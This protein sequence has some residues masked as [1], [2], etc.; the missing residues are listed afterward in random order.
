MNKQRLLNTIIG[1]AIGA[2]L[3]SIANYVFDLGF[4]AIYIG[5]M[6]ATVLIL[7]LL[8]LPWLNKKEKNSKPQPASNLIV[9]MVIF[10]VA[11]AVI[12]GIIIF[13]GESLN[14]GP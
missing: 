10:I 13:I 14:L 9:R 4:N 8:P 6:A 3:I 7:G 2:L 1:V 5:A 11:V 12:V